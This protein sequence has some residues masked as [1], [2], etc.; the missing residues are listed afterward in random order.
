ME[1]EFDIAKNIRLTEELQCRM[2][3]L[4][5]EFFTAMQQNKE[6]ADLTKVLADLQNTLLLLSA[7]LGISSH[8]L[9]QKSISLIKLALLQEEDGVKK[10][11]LLHLLRTMEDRR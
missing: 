6:K 8:V 4:T 7:R 3:T 9:D 10:D 11:A 1:K 5:A 2:L